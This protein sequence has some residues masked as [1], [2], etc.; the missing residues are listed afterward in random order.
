MWLVIFQPLGESE[1]AILRPDDNF[2]GA[3]EKS[4]SKIRN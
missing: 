1:R 3:N 4:A 2:D